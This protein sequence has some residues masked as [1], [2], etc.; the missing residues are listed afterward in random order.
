MYIDKLVLKDTNEEILPHAEKLF[1]HSSY[2]VEPDRFPSGNIPWH[3]H[4]DLELIY[5]LQ[6]EIEIKTANKAIN[7]SSGDAAFINS[8]VMHFQCPVGSVKVITLNQVFHASIIYGSINSVF[9]AN[10]LMPI[11]TCKELDIMTFGQALVA[12]RKIT[13]LIKLSQDLSDEKKTGYEIEVRNALSSMILLIYEKAYDIINEKRL[14][15]SQ[16]E[17]RLKIMM[18]YLHNNYMNKIT[19]L[20][21]SYAANISEREAIRTF[22]NIL[23]LSPFAY[24]MQYRVRMATTLLTES[25]FSIS[26]IAYTCGFCSTSYFGKEFK[27]IMGIT[28]M[29]YRK[30]QR[31]V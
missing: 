27:K 15:S 14:T 6:G 12:D 18:E 4:E 8:N 3:W 26:Q 5:V 9:Y 7:L 16:G 11:L 19:L 28:P 21:I 31:K 23:N 1:P 17:D 20:D 25:G 24:L 22:N 13:Q 10:Y 29:E 30:N 2:Y